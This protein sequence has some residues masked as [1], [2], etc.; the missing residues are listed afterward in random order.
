LSGVS[1]SQGVRPKE[2]IVIGEGKLDASSCYEERI[3]VVME[4]IFQ[5][6]GLN[7][8]LMIRR[9]ICVSDG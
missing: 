6:G 7:H 1:I 4:K 2:T 8:D 9:P 5:C 3:E